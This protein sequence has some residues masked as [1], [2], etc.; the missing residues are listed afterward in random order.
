MIRTISPVDREASEQ[1]KLRHIREHLEDIDEP[2]LQEEP[3]YMDFSG[4]LVVQEMEGRDQSKGETRLESALFPFCRTLND[5]D[6][7]FQNSVSRQTLLGLPS[8]RLWNTK[9]TL[10]Y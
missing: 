8:C 2:T 3:S 1:R 10:F 5:F 9:G 4:Y 7:G 6:F